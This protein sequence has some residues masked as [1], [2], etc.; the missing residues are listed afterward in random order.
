MKQSSIPSGMRDIILGECK[1]KQ[2][3]RRAI[4]KV[5]EAWGYQEIIT[6]TIEYYKTYETGFSDIHE[7]DMY[8]F[9]DGDGKILM[10]RADMTIP[11]ARV[12]A[13]KFKDAPLPL[14]FCYEANVF[15][16]HEDLSGMKNEI[17]DCGV[18]LIGMDEECAELEILIT[19]MEALQVV[20][21]KKIIL[22]IGNINFFREACKEF[23]LDDESMDQLSRLIDQKSLID[24]KEY[25][26]TLKLT[27]KA[28]EFFMQLPWL[29]GEASILEEAKQFAFTDSLLK[30]VERM[31]VLDKQLKAL[32]YS[33]INYDLGKASNLNYYTGLIFEA[34]IEGVGNRVLSGGSYNHL[35]AKFGRDVSAIG[36][37]IKLDSLVEA[38][39]QDNP[40]PRYI[41]EYP[42]DK[43]V[44]ALR[45]R[46]RLASL[47]PVE[48]IVNNEIDEIIVKEVDLECYQ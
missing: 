15:K 11:I 20:K 17:T 26:D 5:F 28:K 14:R 47:Y 12:A 37:S 27:D 39:K 45:K 38:M 33:S 31:Q 2:E 41:L 43:L 4:E 36:F 29:S 13:T 32:G 30:I 48:M 22:E 40:R 6:P 3:L 44:E 16:V 21:N 46:K 34:F 42:K 7:E 23:N 9:F 10:L 1:T 25:L 35:I 8:K 19:A 18:E 24:L